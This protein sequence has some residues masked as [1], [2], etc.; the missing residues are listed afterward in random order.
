M[1]EARYRHN[2]RR[3]CRWK[4]MPGAADGAPTRRGKCSSKSTLIG[5]QV[6]WNKGF[7]N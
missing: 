5:L 7:V 6:L 1:D 4:K 3:K 2:E